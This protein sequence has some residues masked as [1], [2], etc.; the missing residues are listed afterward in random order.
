MWWFMTI[1][2]PLR[3]RRKQKDQ[4]FKACQGY[5]AEALFKKANSRTSEMG[6]GTCCQARWRVQ[7][8]NPTWKERTGSLTLSSDLHIHTCTSTRTLWQHASTYTHTCTQIINVTTTKCRFQFNSSNVCRSSFL[9]RSQVVMILLLSEPYF[10]WD[11]SS[12]GFLFDI[13]LCSKTKDLIW[14]SYNI[15]IKFVFS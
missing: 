6:K 4:K 12:P 14:S 5:I 1:I 15:N 8:L 9:T 7:S 10:D 11:L 2:L 13:I 3:R